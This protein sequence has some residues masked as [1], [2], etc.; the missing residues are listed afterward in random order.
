MELHLYETHIRV[1]ELHPWNIYFFQ[2]TFVWIIELWRNKMYKFINLTIACGRPL[3]SHNSLKPPP[4]KHQHEVTLL[5][6]SR[7]DSWSRHQLT[8]V[9]G[10]ISQVLA[11]RC[12]LSAS[13]GTRSSRQESVATAK[14]A[15]WHWWRFDKSFMGATHIISSA[16]HPTNMFLIDVVPF[17][18]NIIRLPNGVRYMAK[19]H[20]FNKN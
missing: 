8:T 11:V 4:Q 1:C 12:Q 14:K 13:G 3:Q 17:K 15:V 7:P 20:S 16:A 2:L 19:K 6:W 5:N 18:S 10:P 9:A